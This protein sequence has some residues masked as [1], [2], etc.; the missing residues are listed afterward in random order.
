MEIFL[1]RHGETTT[2]VSKIVCGQTDCSLTERGIHQSKM[3]KD[4]L[5]HKDFSY[6]YCS[7]L[8]RAKQTA[9]EIFD[10]DR[11]TIVNDLMEMNT[12]LYSNM[13]VSELWQKFPLY[14][15]QGRYKYQKYPQ[16]ECLSDLYGR[17]GFWFDEEF[18]KWEGDQK[19]L[20]VGHEATVVCILHK[21]FQ[22]PLDNYPTFKIRNASTVKIYLNKEDNQSRMEFL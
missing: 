10:L 1:V 17:I 16:G 12:G 19:I 6:L 20:I 15:Y 22:I 2:N 4:V 21:I 9:K 11:F 7:P 14:K 13:S 3:L 8:I 5:G 18:K